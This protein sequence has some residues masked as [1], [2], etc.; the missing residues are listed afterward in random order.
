[1]LAGQDNDMQKAEM[2]S[3]EG[4]GDKE[5]TMWEGAGCDIIIQRLT[6]GK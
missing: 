6:V 1:M 4:A 3:S 5:A 2:E